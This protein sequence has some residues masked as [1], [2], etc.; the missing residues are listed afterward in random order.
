VFFAVTTYF[1]FKLYIV[2]SH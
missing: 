2:S 1:L